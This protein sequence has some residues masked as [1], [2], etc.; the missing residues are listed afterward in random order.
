M[1]LKLLTDFEPLFNGRLGAW[2]TTPVSFE[3]KEGAKPY[4]RQAFTITKVH[5]ET[6]IRK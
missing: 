4:N 1:L 3:L 2:K 5:K 6:I